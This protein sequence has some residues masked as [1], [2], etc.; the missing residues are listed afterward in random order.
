MTTSQTPGRAGRT[1]RRAA[2]SFGDQA[3]RRSTSFYVG[4]ALV[5]CV[6]VG[7]NF[8]WSLTGPGI[9][10]ASLD[11]AVRSRLSSPAPDPDLLI[12]DIDERSLAQLAPT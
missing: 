8:V 11:L 12:V 7:A 1:L 6:A 2:L 9:K 4:L 10:S 3:R 5:F